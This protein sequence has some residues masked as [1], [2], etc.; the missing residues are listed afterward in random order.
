[1]AERLRQ[2]GLG[3]AAV[4]GLLTVVYGYLGVR[5]SGEPILPNFQ[6][7]AE[8]RTS[9]PLTLALSRKGRGNEM[10]CRLARPMTC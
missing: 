6:T 7:Q 4:L 3:L 1:M 10:P 5:C 8:P 2:A 9:H